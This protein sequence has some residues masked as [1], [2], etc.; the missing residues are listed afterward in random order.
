M[1][2]DFLSKY[3]YLNGL[4]VN[5]KQADFEEAAMSFKELLSQLR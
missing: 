5:E 3:R 1:I 2:D 4:N